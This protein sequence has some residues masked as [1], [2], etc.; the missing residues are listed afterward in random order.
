ML[1]IN[2]SFK[3]QDNKDEV[4]L[5]ILA[6]YQPESCI[7]FC[8]SRDECNKVAGMLRKKK[9]DALTIHSDLEQ[10]DR[11]LTL[12]KFANKTAR[13]LVATDLA[14]RGIDVKGIA[15]IINYDLPLDHE[16]YVHRIGRTGRAGE[17]GVAISL[18]TSKEREVFKSIGDYLKDQ[19]EVMDLDAL[20]KL[21]AVELRAAMTTLYISGGKKNSV[22]PGDILGSIDQRCR[23][24]RSRCWQD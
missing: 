7:I 4:L 10:K 3:A 23:I 14:S 8:N 15:M 18:Y 21:K 1:L 5:R 16:L 17:K 11:T 13:F 22:R 2:F 9:I 24:R 6:H 20:A 12:I 19:C